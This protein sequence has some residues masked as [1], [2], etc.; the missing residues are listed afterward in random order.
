MPRSN[1]GATSMLPAL[2][3]DWKSANILDSD[4]VPHW[5][6]VRLLSYL[7]TL[8][9]SSD[10]NL[11]QRLDLCTSLDRGES[12]KGRL[13]YLFKWIGLAYDIVMQPGTI[14]GKP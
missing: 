14:L 8:M 12:V 9:L 3:L 1:R 5:P 6:L 4:L 11:I 13:I 7:E 10:F 2:G